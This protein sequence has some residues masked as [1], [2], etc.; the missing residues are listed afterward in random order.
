M[1][2]AAAIRRGQEIKYNVGIVTIKHSFAYG[3]EGGSFSKE[4]ELEVVI[5]LPGSRSCKAK[6]CYDSHNMTE[7]DIA[8]SMA[9]S[10]WEIFE[11][12]Q[13]TPSW[14]LRGCIGF[15]KHLTKR[16]GLIFMDTL[17]RGLS[18]TKDVQY[19]SEVEEVEN[20][21]ES[22]RYLGIG[23]KLMT[24]AIVSSNGF[25][26]EKVSKIVEKCYEKLQ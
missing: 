13:F 8:M 11:Q 4:R 22:L 1:A 18:G 16:M 6:F 12:R 26:S 5:K 14:I 23:P 2:E 24:Q 10:L 19:E 7:D 21:T 17:V 3:S 25:E 15:S 9:G 20:L